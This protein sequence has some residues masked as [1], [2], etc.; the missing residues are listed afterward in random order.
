MTFSRPPYRALMSATAM[1]RAC[2]A[3]VFVVLLAARCPSSATDSLAPSEAATQSPVTT[4]R[5]AYRLSNGLVEI[6]ARFTNTTGNTVYLRQCAREVL[7]FI[8][9]RDGDGWRIG[10]PTY[11]PA[12]LLAPAFPVA[13]GASL[14]I[15]IILGVGATPA[16]LTGTFRIWVVA[17]TDVSEN[18]WEVR[19]DLLPDSLTRSRPFTISP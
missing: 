11:C 10:I 18:G 5:A 16:E 9:R 13:P 2:G 7:T 3:M 12:T 14:T 4:D 1:A 8:E 6:S 19:G 17:G 15:P